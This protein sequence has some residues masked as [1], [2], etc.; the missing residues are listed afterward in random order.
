MSGHHPSDEL[1]GGRVEE[2]R[3]LVQEGIDSGPAHDAAEVFADIREKG[4]ARGAAIALR[5]LSSV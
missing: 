5:K 4:R 2:L 3:A 1:P